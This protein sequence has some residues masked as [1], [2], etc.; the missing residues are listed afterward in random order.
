[1]RDY[2]SDTIAVRCCC[3]PAKVLGW[4]P[5][6]AGV[7]WAKGGTLY[8]MAS[9][10][11]AGAEEPPRIALEMAFVHRGPGTAGQRALKSMNLPIGTLRSIVGWQEA[12]NGLQDADE[13]HKT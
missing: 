6:P 12:D 11:V 3:Q 9:T 7:W 4:V 2:H 5:A 13:H 8:P 1:M 10:V